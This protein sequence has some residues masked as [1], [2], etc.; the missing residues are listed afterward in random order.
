MG[1]NVGSSLAHLFYEGYIHMRV[2]FMGTPDFA[3]PTLEGLVSAGHE[4]VAVVSQPDRPFGRKGKLLSPPVAVRAR[5]LGI[6]L[7]QPAHLKSKDVAAEFVGLGADVFVVA[8]YGR[9]LPK[10][11]LEIPRHGCIN[12]HASLLPKYRGAAPIQH[13]LING[14]TKTGVTIMQMDEGLDTG[15]ILLMR[16]MQVSPTDDSGSLHK[17]LSHIGADALLE[18]LECLQANNGGLRPTPQDHDRATLAPP[19]TEEGSKINWTASAQSITNF[20][21]ALHPRPIAWTIL[22]DGCTRFKIYEAQVVDM[23]M[24]GQSEH[25]PGRIVS[26]GKGGILVAT[27]DTDRAVRLVRL[28]KQGAKPLQDT[29]FI[30]G[31][32]LNTS[33]TFK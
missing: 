11:M 10:H 31:T 4:V 26:V 13:A 5:E 3:L 8:A 27:G 9:I 16:E 15:A 29:E 24:V 18:V 14:E 22:D 28:Q 7:I 6:P 19:I 17:H 25:T 12:V 2:V 21:R 23:P 33:N 20:V 30:N 32:R 1:Y